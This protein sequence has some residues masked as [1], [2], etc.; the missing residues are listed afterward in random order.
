M[1]LTLPPE[2]DI[3]EGDEL[4]PCGCVKC[5]LWAR[6]WKVL[7]DFREKK[8]CDLVKCALAARERKI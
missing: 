7:R 1:R 3:M 5:A 4:H 8:P 6:E 2:G